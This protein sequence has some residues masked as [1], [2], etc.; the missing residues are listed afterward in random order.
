MLCT[1]PTEAFV[2]IIKEDELLMYGK[3]IELFYQCA[4]APDYTSQ[5]YDQTPIFIKLY[6]AMFNSMEDEGFNSKRKKLA[7]N[8]LLTKSYSWTSDILLDILTPE[9]IYDRDLFPNIVDYHDDLVALD[10]FGKL[11]V[12]FTGSGYEFD[13]RDIQIGALNQKIFKEFERTNKLINM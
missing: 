12:Y 1:I 5:K 9:Y 13:M 4:V 6:T 2:S 11:M 10:L 7:L 3:Y 8:T